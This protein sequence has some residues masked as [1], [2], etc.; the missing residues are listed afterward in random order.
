[1]DQDIFKIGSLWRCENQ[2]MIDFD[3]DSFISGES[4]HY[5]ANIS[6]DAMLKI[7]QRIPE[8]SR[9]HL[10]LV[11][12]LQKT[13]FSRKMK[14]VKTEENPQ[15]QQFSFKTTFNQKFQHWGFYYLENDRLKRLP[16]HAFDYEIAAD[17]SIQHL[18]L[19]FQYNKL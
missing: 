12:S 15:M 19:F 10:V 3:T 8:T 2:K 1:M 14:Q 9:I 16:I 13:Y 5:C 11:G 17:E 4:K 7:L 6:S 18:A